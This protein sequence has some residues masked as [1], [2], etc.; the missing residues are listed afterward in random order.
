MVKSGYCQ[1]A[2]DS[3]DRNTIYK[4]KWEQTTRFNVSRESNEYCTSTAISLKLH[5]L[6]FG[7]KIDSFV[8]AISLRSFLAD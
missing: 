6:F 4:L 3:S 5:Q 8:T 1:N 7:I 2:R